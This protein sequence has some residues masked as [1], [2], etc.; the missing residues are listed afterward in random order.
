MNHASIE[1]KKTIL[2]LIIWIVTAFPITEGTFYAMNSM[3]SF[4][5]LVGMFVFAVWVALSGFFL[6]YS[7]K[8]VQYYF[9]NIKGS[10]NEDS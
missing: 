9:T 10:T 7:F 6:Y 3:S 4:F 2:Y 1:V 8:K 5:V